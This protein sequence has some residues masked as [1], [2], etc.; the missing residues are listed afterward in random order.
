M[1]FQRPGE[2][3]AHGLIRHRRDELQLRPTRREPADCACKV[4]AQATHFANAAA[5]QNRHGR[6]LRRQPKLPAGGARVTV[7]GNHIGERMTDELGA[8]A[9][10]RVELLLERQQ[11]KHQIDGRADTAHAPLSP[12]P[13][14]RT[15]VLHGAKPRGSQ[16]A[17]QPEIEFRRIDPDEHI[18]ALRQQSLA[19]AF[20]HLQQ[21]RQVPQ[22]LE[23]PHDRER[24][25]V[26]PGFA[27]L[28][29]HLRARDAEESRRRT[30]CTQ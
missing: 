1:P 23:K 18:R 19:Q 24:F 28:R 25:G 30:A 9:G 12:R 10:L 7:F 8:N 13:H 20:A 6:A 26:R 11:A 3:R 22:H 17:C 5:G 2:D 4:I 29:L 15:H 14:L 16:I 21:P 27:A